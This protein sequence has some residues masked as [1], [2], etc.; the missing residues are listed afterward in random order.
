MLQPPLNDGKSSMECV[1]VYFVTKYNIHIDYSTNLKKKK[2]KA[3]KNPH[4]LFLVC[5]QG[6]RGVK[7]AVTKKKG[8]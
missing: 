5:I 8:S 2:T 4:P 1:Y 3:R 6:V 7:F